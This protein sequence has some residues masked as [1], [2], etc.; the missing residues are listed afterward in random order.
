LYARSDL[1]KIGADLGVTATTWAINFAVPDLADAHAERM[2]PPR[3]PAL[4]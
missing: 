3:L 1:R 4:F 2:T